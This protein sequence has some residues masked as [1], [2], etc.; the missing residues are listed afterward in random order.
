MTIPNGKTQLRQPL[1]MTKHY[2]MQE[3]TKG[4]IYQ[5]IPMVYAQVPYN[6]PPKRI[7]QKE[8]IIKYQLQKNRDLSAKTDVSNAN[9]QDTKPDSADLDT[10]TNRI[11]QEH[12]ITTDTNN[13][14]GERNIQQQH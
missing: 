12:R 5:N 8:D 1:A 7:H 10:R 4:R 3:N 2:P 14:L 6:I 9:K 13:R 11:N